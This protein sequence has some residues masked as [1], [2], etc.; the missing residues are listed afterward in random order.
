MMEVG[1]EG[2]LPS[3]RLLARIMLFS[4]AKKQSLR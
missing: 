1:S 4:P 2:C 3:F